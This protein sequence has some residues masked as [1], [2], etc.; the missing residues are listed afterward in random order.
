MNHNLLSVVRILIIYL[1]LVSN[2]FAQS[3][4]FIKEKDGIRIYTRKETNSSLKS[5]MGVA[6][7]QTTMAKVCSLIGNVRNTSWW[8]EN[9]RQ[10]NVLSFEENKHMQYYLIYHAPWPVSDRD[11]CVDAT[12]TTDSMTGRRTIY[13][14][15]LPDRIPEKPDLV[16]IR[17]YWQ[18]WTIQPMDKGIVHLVL[19]GFVDPGG[20]IPS[21]LY[22]MVIT[23]TP[24]N[25][26]RGIQKRVT[27][28]VVETR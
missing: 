14:V 23:E 10:I 19:E 20:S 25:I 7:V 2:L 4:N 5:F 27:A 11:L 8:D 18:R 21:W 24:L 16:R 1:A 13:S 26:L 12:I 15:P 3:W 28:N 6:D 9:V 17:K 22:N